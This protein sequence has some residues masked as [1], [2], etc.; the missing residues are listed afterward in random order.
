MNSQTLSE[1]SAA[2]RRSRRQG[3]EW[4][5]SRLCA[6]WSLID[7]LVA[8]SSLLSS[9]LSFVPS[10]PRCRCT[11][12]R[13]APTATGAAAPSTD[14]SS[15]LQSTPIG[16]DRMESDRRPSVPLCDVRP[17]C[18]QRNG[19]D[20]GG[21]RCSTCGSD[22]SRRLQQPRINENKQN[23]NKTKQT[24]RESSKHKEQQNIIQ[25][26]EFVH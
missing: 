9:S 1:R 14:E 10:F 5:V 3:M 13:A 15:G 8:L 2:E 4:L 23:K 18:F 20:E 17:R 16:S 7:S 26:T 21:R 11:H 22:C 24:S 19:L 6:G 25:S 12:F